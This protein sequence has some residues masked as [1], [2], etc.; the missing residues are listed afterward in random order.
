M[1]DDVFE[2]CPW[3]VPPAAIIR[4]LGITEER[5]K[6]SE[7]VLY[8]LLGR[9]KKWR[10][11]SKWKFCEVKAKG[12]KRRFYA[13]NGTG[14]KQEVSLNRW[15]TFEKSWTHGSLSQATSL[16]MLSSVSDLNK[17]Q[18]MLLQ[19]LRTFHD[20]LMLDKDD[21]FHA[22]QTRLRSLDSLGMI[23]LSLALDASYVPLMYLK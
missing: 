4:H 22:Y 12:R 8:Q 15:V 11:V 10:Y 17:G 23:N 3:P 2:D 1:L 9:D 5:D 14:T 13:I 16:L 20:V 7:Q 19:T 6:T 21:P 18:S